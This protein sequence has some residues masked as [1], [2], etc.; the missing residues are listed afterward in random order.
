MPYEAKQG[1]Y[2]SWEDSDGKTLYGRIKSTDTAAKTVVITG[3]KDGAEIA[4]A[5]TSSYT[6]I[7]KSNWGRMKMRAKPN[8]WEVAENVVTGAIY[9]PLV[10]RDKLMDAEFYSFVLADITHE[11]ITKGF[12]ESIADMLLPTTLE[13]SDATDFFS[14]SDFSDALRKAP[15]V[16]ALQQLYQKALFRKSWGH[17]IASNAI[18]DF[19]ILAVS[20]VAD[21]MWSAKEDGYTYP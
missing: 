10:A 4:S 1:D 13:G 17:N 9:F 11:F 2:I 19:V 12:S 15:F 7:G 5:A 3:Y 14:T 20:N 21:R 6:N 18:G 8:A 16:L